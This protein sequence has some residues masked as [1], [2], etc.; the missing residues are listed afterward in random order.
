MT[1]NPL[2][3]WSCKAA[4]AS[5]VLGFRL[6][7]DDIATKAKG[8]YTHF[9]SLSLF[10]LF[11]VNDEFYYAVLCSVC[12]DANGDRCSA[13]LWWKQLKTRALKQR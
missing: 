2:A 9:P 12:C 1:P 11:S 10:S 13:A 5:A 6:P 8:N 7:R 3:T 4:A